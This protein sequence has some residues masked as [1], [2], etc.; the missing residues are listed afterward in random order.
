MYLSLSE[1]LNT[2]QKSVEI[3]STRRTLI[4][5]AAVTI[6]DKI[7][8]NEKLTLVYVCTHNSRRSQFSQVWS[9]VLANKY[10]LSELISSASAGTETTACNERTVASLKRS[11]FEVSTSDTG[12]NPVYNCTFEDNA[13]DI[14]LWSK[15]LDHPSLEQ[16]M[17][18]IMTCSDADENCPFVPGAIA[19]IRLTFE[20]PK[21]SD[22]TATEQAT[23]DARS[24]Q[25]A[26]ELSY[27]FERLMISLS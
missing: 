9:A 20:D 26:A 17:I 22:D 25:I 7:R 3:A 27:L 19:R 15:T 24:A 18:A 14:K 2:A 21:I 12:S 6:A 8:E 13:P 1:F 11:G 23:Y 10:A 5:E 16:P 4:E